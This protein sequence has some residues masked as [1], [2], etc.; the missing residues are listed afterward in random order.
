MAEEAAWT[1]AH[2]RRR[3]SQVIAPAHNLG[4]EHC[5]D[6]IG[7]GGFHP[8]YGRCQVSIM[9]F[10]AVFAGLYDGFIPLLGLIFSDW[11]LS[12][13]KAQEVET[14]VAVAFLLCFQGV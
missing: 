4:V 1:Q 11:E 8:F 6:C 10:Y 14:H 7:G 3:K 2:V 12:N 9:S 5:D 13:G